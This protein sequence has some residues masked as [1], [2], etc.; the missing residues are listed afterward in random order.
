MFWHDFGQVGH[1]LSRTHRYHGI[2][3]SV[4]EAGMVQAN[5]GYKVTPLTFS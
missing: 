2:V 3:V 1:S 4:A 5:V